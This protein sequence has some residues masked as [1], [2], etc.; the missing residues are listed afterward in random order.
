MGTAKAWA[1][2]A[3]A[4]WK[5]VRDDI[6]DLLDNPT[7]D[8]ADSLLDP[9]LDAIDQ[10]DA[11]ASADPVPTEPA[12]PDAPPSATPPLSAIPMRRRGGGRGGG[13]GGA[14]FG[15]SSRQN[16]GRKGRSRRSST[17][18]SRVAGDVLAAGLALGRGDADA[19]R[20]LGL[21]L[22][23]LSGLSPMKQAQKILNVLV[24]TGGA[25]EEN[26]LRAANARA[27]R[28]LLVQGLSGADAVRV[29]VVEYVMQIYSSECGEASRDGSRPGEDSAEV[30]KQLRSALRV[31]VR[32][33]E[34]PDDIV[35]SSRLAQVIR[36]ALKTMR[37]VRPG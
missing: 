29:F 1:G 21:N 27:L 28:Q 32:Q 23:E 4:E 10:D 8:G 25:V 37:K 17:R 33:L 15:G 16:T 12:A 19:L 34:I 24:G 7:Q 2:T 13:G 35:T 26:E 11:P 36:E 5:R 6:D 14:I 3:S 9:L 20:D 22:V 18:A 31:R 30:E